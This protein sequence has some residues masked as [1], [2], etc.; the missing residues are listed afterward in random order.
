MYAKSAYYWVAVLGTA[1]FMIWLTLW[2]VILY[3]AGSLPGSPLSGLATPMYFGMCGGTLGFWAIV[4][5]TRWGL[6]F[7]LRL[8]TYGGF[9]VLFLGSMPIRL[10]PNP[11]V[12][13]GDVAVS[14]LLW[15]LVGA[16]VGGKVAV[17][18][19]WYRMFVLRGIT[20][21]HNAASHAG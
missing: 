19:F 17:W 20:S 16:V 13:V 2:D 12:Y 21:L 10:L 5:H 7:V 15:S 8:R 18:I 11:V 6:R 3:Y 4:Q 1:I 9:V 14:M